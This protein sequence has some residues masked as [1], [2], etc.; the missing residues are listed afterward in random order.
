M[1][2]ASKGLAGGFVVAVLCGTC[3]TRGSKPPPAWA[4]DP[5]AQV[6][7][8]GR[9]APPPAIT[10]ESDPENIERR[11]GFAEAKA[12]RE[13]AQQNAQSNS[14]LVNA[15]QAVVPIPQGGE[16][17]MAPNPG[18]PGVV[19]GAPDA[20]ARDGGRARSPR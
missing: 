16:P 7:G 5:Q 20:G 13:T 8:P 15:S 3:A 19:P 1:S 18:G 2:L 4:A 10:P 9:S 11:F 17:A 12:R 6:P 14:R